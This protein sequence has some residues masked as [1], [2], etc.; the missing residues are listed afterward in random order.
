MITFCDSSNRQLCIG[1]TLQ[2]R[3]GFLGRTKIIRRVRVGIGEHWA[4]FDYRE[5][6][7]DFLGG[8]QIAESLSSSDGPVFIAN[9]D[10]APKSSLFQEQVAGV[11]EHWWVLCF[12]NFETDPVQAAFSPKDFDEFLS[13]ASEG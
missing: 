13:L 12:M 9:V 2:H 7:Q 4:E 5:L 1:Q 10:W 8:Q 3:K 11:P 6:T